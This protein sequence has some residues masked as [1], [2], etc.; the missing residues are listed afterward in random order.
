MLFGKSENAQPDLAELADDSHDFIKYFEN[1][2]STHALHTYKSA[3]AF[4]PR[5]TS[6][7]RQY[8]HMYRELGGV[9]H[10]CRT[11][12]RSRIV[13]SDEWNS[14][15]EC[16]TFSPDRTRFASSS[17]GTINFW[18]TNSGMLVGKPLKVGNDLVLS[19]AFSTD[20]TRLVSGSSD[21]T[22]QL[23]NPTSG[24]RIGKPFV[25]HIDFVI[26][27]TFSQDGSQVASGSYEHSVRLWNP[28]SGREIRPC[29]EGHTDI[30]RALAFSPNG[31][32]LASASGDGTIRLWDVTSGT[33]LN[34]IDITYRDHV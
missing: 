27:V 6:F 23:W 26:C 2:L 32:R 20:G 11:T 31:A 1:I 10:S 4:V 7:W 5:K 14:G 22:V 24:A 8:R 16:V 18:D 25:G 3:L 12:W 33:T 21:N 29:L 15:V 34:S 28:V 13:A 19:I 9:D 30:I 17:P